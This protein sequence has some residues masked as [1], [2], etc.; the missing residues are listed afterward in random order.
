[1]GHVDT[2]VVIPE[3]GGV[4]DADAGLDEDGFCPGAAGV[5]GFDH[6][7]SLVRVAPEDV[8][9]SVVMAYAGGPDALAVLGSCVACRGNGPRHGGADDGPVDEVLR[10]EYLE[11]GDAVE[12]GRG[13]VEVVADAA[14]VG[15]GVVSVEH[16]VLVRAVALVGDPDLRAVWL[17]LLCREGQCEGQHEAG[18]E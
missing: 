11:S 17:G 12:T 6:E 5:L 10:V 2:A 13:E 15:V 4:D 8:E 9:P 3:R 7:S 18:E 16:G 14:C 1:M